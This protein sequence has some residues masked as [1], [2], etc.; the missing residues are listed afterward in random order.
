MEFDRRICHQGSRRD[1]TFE[2]G[3]QD[4]AIYSGREAEIVGIDDQSSHR[5]S[6]T[7]AQSSGSAGI[8]LAIEPR[9]VV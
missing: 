9:G 1:D 3:L 2:V 4:G 6:L 8:Y 5:G 7:G